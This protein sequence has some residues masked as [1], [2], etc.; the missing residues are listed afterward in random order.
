M[1]VQVLPRPAD[2]LKAV[3]IYLNLAYRGT[4]P[5]AVRL[6]V[7]TLRAMPDGEFYESAVLQKDSSGCMAKFFLRLGNQTYPHMKLALFRQPD[8]AWAFAVEEHDQVGVPT[9]SSREYHF[10]SKMVAHNREL[11]IEIER[12]WSVAGLLVQSQGADRWSGPRTQARA[13][14]S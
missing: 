6:R 5:S 12:A 8:A 14:H 9:P 1:V 7:E 3:D 2:F 13:L 11:A 4:P 10:F